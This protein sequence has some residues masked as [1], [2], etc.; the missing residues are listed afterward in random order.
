M[1]KFVVLAACLVLLALIVFI[2][3]RYVG[4]NTFVVTSTGF[5]PFL[6]ASYMAYL[7]SHGFAGVL[8]D[9]V[10]QIEISLAWQ[11]DDKL[12][13][14]FYAD[15]AGFFNLEVTYL[16]LAGTNSSIFRAIYLNGEML[17]DGLRQ[18]VFNRFWQDDSANIVTI[19]NNEVRPRRSEVFESRTVF[20]SDAGRRD[21]TPYVFFL[22]EGRGTLTFVEIREPMLIE[23]LRFVAAVPVPTYEEY[24]N[25]FAGMPIFSGENLVF[26][27]ERIMGGTLGV[28]K[29]STSITMQSAFFDPSLVPF[30]SYNI[31]FN[32]IGGDSWR[33]PG[34]KIQWTIYVPET[35]M[36]SISFRGRQSGNRGVTSYRRLTINGEPPFSEAERLPFPFS[37]VLTNYVLPFQFFF[38]RGVNT[39]ALEVVL[40]DFNYAYS[41]V[42]E[43]VRILN[44]LAHRIIQIT[45]VAPDRFIDYR[46]PMQV[47]EYI[48]T[49]EQEVKRLAAVVDNLILLTGGRGENTT[50]IERMV[51]QMDSLLLRPDNITLELN[52]F[53]HNIASLATWLITISEMPLELDSFTLKP[54]GGDPGPPR[55][56]F[57]ARQQNNMLRFAATFFVD[58][59]AVDT[60]F[61]AMG[62]DALRV[63]IP[64]GRDQAQ[65][66]GAL[67]DE[68]FVPTY[69]IPVRLQ[70]IPV[71]V[72]V[73]ATLAGEGPDV[74]I[75]INQTLLMD[76]AVRNALVALSDQPGFAEEAERFFPSAIEG[77]S[78]RGNTYGLPETQTFGIVFYRTDIMGELG[79][80]PPATW[81]EVR[82]MIPILHRHNYEIW[83]PTT[84][85]LNSKILQ[86]GGHIYQ[87]T[88]DDFGI[89]SG[90][91]EE[92]AM[93]A[94]RQ[95]TEFYTAFR[96]PVV[97]DFAN[98][99]RTGE[100]PIGIA[101]YTLYHTLSLFAPEIRGL[102]SFALIPGTKREDGT[103]DNTITAGT[104]QTV[105][106]TAARS[107]GVE[108]EAWQ[109]IRWW[110]SD[111]IQLEYALGI[112]SILGAA[113][114]YPTANP[115]VLRQLPW[116]SREAALLLEQFER[117]RGIPAVP[118]HYMS[119]RMVQY[120]FNDVVT[121]FANPRELLFLNV[122]AIDQ[123]LTRKR[124]EFGFSFWDEERGVIVRD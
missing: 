30:H 56:S 99:F 3:E 84:A 73:P 25:R 34:E 69:G 91:L 38:E 111:D 104:T 4:G 87:G 82:A 14:P 21:T 89:L 54:P 96:L 50:F 100:I 106:M 88:G 65:V 58:L 41:Q 103:I 45:G 40:G 83:L 57:L 52:Q 16:P 93:E 46:I 66:L 22:P 9:G 85:L 32:T 81:D 18:V 44:R 121:R 27:A 59:H 35:G 8:S 115:N 114:R 7:D 107:R 122:R 74:V 51:M 119:D 19:N 120:T 60:Y 109:F 23:S 28:E 63:W 49:L 24:R 124:Q 98:R 102:W 79:L 108:E 61:A 47:P 1:K 80:S 101:D 20:V 55:A 29:T 68:R 10:V 42:S 33:F 116:T 123:E 6:E 110:L 112:E 113:A 39:I 90:L 72:V 94:F 15:S 75:S 95:L 5:S 12:H 92:P 31:V 64:T 67:I 43:S 36:Y 117:T 70:L 2:T 118:G 105:M 26:Q 17:H 48:P 97:V 86:A 71:E 62:A 76:F 77:I 11:E 78:I 53:R 13:F 37:T